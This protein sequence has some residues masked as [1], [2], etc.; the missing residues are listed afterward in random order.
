MRAFISGVTGQD[1]SYLAELLL[2]KGYDVYGLIRRKSNYSYI[3]IQHILNEI[4]LIEGDMTDQISLN[5]AIKEVNPDEVYNMAA[6]SFVGTSW[7]QPLQTSDVTALGC[8]R[9][10][11]AV[12]S[13]APDCKVYQASSSEMFGD[14]NS[15]PQNELTPFRPISPYAI[16]KLYAYWM[17]VNYREGFGLFTCNGILFNHESERR[18]IEFVSRKITDGVAR[19][20]LG[21]ANKLE[22]GNLWSKRD[23]GYAPE[24]C[25]A[26]WRMMQQDKPDDYIVATNETHTVIEFVEEAFNLVN[27]KWEDYVV[28]SKKFMRPAEVPIL[29][30]DYSKANK[31]LG[32][33]PKIK[34]KELVKIMVESD[35]KKLQNGK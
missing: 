24:Y 31:I 2:S 19:I 10:L 28:E 18:G 22:L 9:I 3:N 7:I 26:M 25:E 12:K 1:G 15:H 33:K 23:W 4:E 32:W 13:N 21:L 14:V 17:T 30:G 35:L 34:F 8:L 27:L 20:K 11:E 6:Q 29:Q 16:S 5:K